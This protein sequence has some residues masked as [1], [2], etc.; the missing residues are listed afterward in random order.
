[1]AHASFK[2]A[3]QANET[4]LR[5]KEMFQAGGMSSSESGTSAIMQSRTVLRDVV[6]EMGL[7]V[8][9]KSP[10]WLTTLF[11]RAWD[12]IAAELGKKIADPDPFAFQRVK[13]EGEKT[14]TFFL[15]PLDAT[16][17]EVYNAKKESLGTWSLSQVFSVG[18]FQGTLTRFPKQVTAHK[19]YC[20]NVIPWLDT[21]EKVRKSLEVKPFK[22]EKL[23][24]GLSFIHRD[25]FLAT[26]ILNQVMQSYQKFMRKENEELMGYQRSYLEKRQNELTR[27]WEDSLQEHVC[28]LKNNLDSGGYFSLYQEMEMLSQPRK[29]FT[30]KLF[31]VD[32]ELK[33]LQGIP[34]EAYTYR[35]P[36]NPQKVLPR[37]SPEEVKKTTP[38]KGV[39]AQKILEDDPGI[40][41]NKMVVNV[42]E[43]KK[44]QWD[45]KLF[46]LE[47][48]HE[49][50]AAHVRPASQLQQEILD[51]ARQTE[52][53][54][55]VLEKWEKNQELQMTHDPKSLAGLWVQEIA[56]M[57]EK[58]A[59]STGAE[60]KA[61][62]EKLSLERAHFSEQLRSSIQLLQHKQHAL[63]ENLFVQ[64]G[65]MQ[66][67]SGLTLETA[68]ALYLTYNTTRDGLQAQL[69]Q[70]IYL[71]EELTQ[72]D[73]ELSSITT[74]LSD[75]V[76]L[77]M[78]SKASE[79][80]V[81]LRDSNNRSFREQD[82][83]KEA[84]ATQKK[85]IGHHLGQTIELLKLRAK[86]IDDKILSLQ[87][88]TMDLLRQEKKLIEEKLQEISGKMEDLPEKWRREN[89]LMLKKELG[90]HMIGG[91]TQL[92]ET[93]NIDQ[94]LFQVGSKALDP[95]YL[96]IHPRPPHLVLY[97]F[98]ATFLSALFFY[99]YHLCKGI[100]KGLPVSHESL[101]L[102]GYRSLGTLSLDCNSPIS[103]MR[104]LD[105][106]TL[107]R[108]S[109]FIIAS[110]RKHLC[111]VLVG[112]KNP[113]Y[114]HRLAELLSMQGCKVLLVQYVFDAAP[115]HQIPGLWHYLQDDSVP[116][117]V[118]H[119]DSYDYLP[120]GGTSRHGVE[121]LAH[122]KFQSF[123]NKVK[124]SY[125]YVLIYSK[126]QP[127]FAEA[128][129]FLRVADLMVVTTFEEKK[130]DL[131]VFK[132]WDSA[133]ETPCAAFVC[134]DPYSV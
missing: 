48:E 104:D 103:E 13:Y 57:Q 126:A 73:F 97:L 49:R 72:P 44:Q 129:A 125:D 94:H 62:E 42:L 40:S 34:L 7:Q 81:L 35:D 17:F 4:A 36:Y 119:L 79:T 65:S 70:L 121:M 91:L 26:R 52:E 21:I 106:E 69:R 105:L 132:E 38:Q 3:P 19:M 15:K 9:M 12:N 85:F 25:R 56:K 29:L 5:L 61:L 58:I 8:E 131:S 10:F 51:L 127:Q 113:D 22:Q 86:L 122:P 31:D 63:E 123:L 107:R 88:T 130:E 114:S 43:D 33:R 2:Q 89:L 6:E 20:F 133:K 90:M 95:S 55:S 11:A 24:L 67:F 112:G 66:E 77:A 47:L 111:G 98:I 102:N 53:A 59:A 23:I 75:P 18:E 120:S 74:I 64:Q 80:A 71:S 128:Q 124:A 1:M 30:S 100:L 60:K 93:K 84:L 41:K 82:H 32:L 16:R 45:R 96:P 118:R 37:K 50:L 109:Q 110:N 27:K 92:A 78:V 14:S 115:S 39:T 108:I 117:A 54:E 99:F 134:C 76:T 87:Q 68:Q 101:L 83:L 46:A 116:L 28:Y